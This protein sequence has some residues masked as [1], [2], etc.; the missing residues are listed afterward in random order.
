MDTS[1][2]ALMQSVLAFF[3]GVI[4]C[5]VAILAYMHNAQ[6][7][8]IVSVVTKEV[9]VAGKSTTGS[10]STIATPEATRIA[11]PPESHIEG[12]R[13][14]TYSPQQIAVNPIPT[15]P[16]EPVPQASS[17][18]AKQTDYSEPAYFSS[19]ISAQNVPVNA[20]LICV[21]G[22]GLYSE[23]FEDL[24]RRLCRKGFPTY[25][26]DARG[27]G[28]YMKTDKTLDFEGTV[29]DVGEIIKVV[30]S[31]Y[32]RVPIVLIGESMGG[33]TVI[34][35]GA[36]YQNDIAG[37][38]ASAPGDIRYRQGKMDLK[39]GTKLLLHPNKR[40]EWGDDLLHMATSNTKLWDK[41]HAD[42][43]VRMKLAPKELIQFDSFM[44]KTGDAAKKITTVPMLFLHGGD[45]ELM[46]V[47]GTVELFQ[48][49]PST[50]K[51]LFILG[52]REHVM[53]EEGQF[54]DKTIRLIET[55][56]SNSIKT[57]I[58]QPHKS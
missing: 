50:R 53:L 3:I 11:K 38:I 37:I 27:F 4:L 52:Q 47:K 39:V 12:K 10:N 15:G 7:K 41:W 26:M 30:K 51:D 19:W 20:V 58:V 48:D 36:Q 1:K 9:V 16:I 31:K 22:F 34:H 17:T 56:L 29:K 32:P 24:G 46:K 35:A 18:S 14:S 2:K 8:E 57:P 42:P 45:D 55:W 54:D 5:A 43:L 25:S 49:V 33:A 6:H 13:P 28:R 23:A 44:G 40:V 21:H